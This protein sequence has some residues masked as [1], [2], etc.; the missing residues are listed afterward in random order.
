MKWPQP[1]FQG[2]KAR[3]S[4]LLVALLSLSLT[5]PSLVNAAQQKVLLRDVQTLTLHK[6]RMTTGRRSSPVPQ[7]NCV[8]GNACGD[9][10]PGK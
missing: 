4:L 3:I 8:G 7:V 1:S 9:Y 5:L 2:A 10:E 6:G